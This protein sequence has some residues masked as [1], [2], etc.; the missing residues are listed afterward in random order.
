M[1][2]LENDLKAAREIV[3][4]PDKR[5]FFKGAHSELRE[6]VAIAVAE[7]VAFGWKQGLELGATS[8]EKEATLIADRIRKI[9]N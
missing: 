9:S 3:G 8:L 5:T 4:P 1:N 6:E 2:Y 7:G